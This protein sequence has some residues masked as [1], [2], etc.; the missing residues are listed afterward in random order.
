[1]LRGTGILAICS[2]VRMLVELTE[3]TSIGLTEREPTT[4]T[5]PS[6]VAPAAVAPKLT[7]VPVPTLTVTSRTAVLPSAR[8]RVTR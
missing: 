4:V 6:S 8:F 7:G 2:A 3:D 5:W 1:M